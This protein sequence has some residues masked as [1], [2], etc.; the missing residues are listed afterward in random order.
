M[1]K[2][3]RIL[4]VDDDPDV[5]LAVRMLL[6]PAVKEIVTE[7]NPERLPNLLAKEKF[8]IILLDMN[9]KSSLNTGNEGI[10]WLRKIREKDKNVAVISV[11]G[12]TEKPESWLAN[13]YYLST[14]PIDYQV[15]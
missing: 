9:Y 8:D 12:T 2:N 15:Q 7:S 3:A 6:R 4:A 13:F 1:L 10:F 14:S 5:L 11:R